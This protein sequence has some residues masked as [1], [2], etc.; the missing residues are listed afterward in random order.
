[1][2][3]EYCLVEKWQENYILPKNITLIAISPQA[4]YELDRLNIKYS[5]LNDFH[6]IDQIKRI[7]FE[8]HFTNQLSWFEEFDNLIQGV[9]LEAKKFNLKLA[10]L[11][12]YNIKYLI[13]H[14]IVNSSELKSFLDRAQPSKVWYLENINTKDQFDQWHWFN[15]GQNSYFRIIK[16][17][18]NKRNIECEK[19]TLTIKTTH[20]TNLNNYSNRP[21]FILQ[22]IKL[23]ISNFFPKIIVFINKIRTQY[24]LRNIIFSNN[25]SSIES[26]SFFIVKIFDSSLEFLHEISKKGY[27]ISFLKNNNYKP[28]FFFSKSKKIPFITKDEIISS[29]NIRINKTIETFSNNS[30]MNWININCGIDVSG[31]LTSRFEYLFKN[32]F[33]ET[34]GLI[35][36]F[37]KLFDL[38]N[39][40]Y[41]FTNSLATTYDFAAVA[42]ARLSKKTK[43][44]GFFHGI[45]VV[46]L[47]ERFF[48]EYNNFDLY[49]TST[50][51]ELRYIKELK[52]EFNSL[53][54]TLGTIPYYRNYFTNKS[55]VNFSSKKIKRKNVILFLS[56]VRK[57]RNSATYTRKHLTTMSAIRWHN[58]LLE[59][60][61]TRSDFNFIWK[62]NAYF[63]NFDDSIFKTINNKN[64][65]NVI[66]ENRKLERVLPIVSKVICDLPS[67]GFFECIMSGYPSITFSEIDNNNIQEG[68]FSFLGNSLKSYSTIDE[69]LK[70]VVRFLDDNPD[71][72]FVKIPEE[73]SL[74]LEVLNDNLIHC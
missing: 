34:I 27:S 46:G 19:M 35:I 5:T 57:R 59:Y 25:S 28:S 49:F 23:L 20:K 16:P 60:F 72:Y 10:T 13:D 6:T 48:M 9:Y 38:E 24:K 42:A 62:D 3:I 71:K 41:I 30:L 8:A 53:H 1:M 70:I 50:S 18:C 69:K 12:Y 14:L 32:T 21:Y 54:P 61:S 52:K 40:N 45:D 22:R 65:K 7:D 26:K 29:N 74:V 73:K 33:P 67:T 43:S 64:Y 37:R 2:L 17:L 55:I 11:Y 51:Y 44:I 36:G 39:I 68:A 31:L 66:Y 63:E 4:C 47:K 56:I 58:A 15:Y